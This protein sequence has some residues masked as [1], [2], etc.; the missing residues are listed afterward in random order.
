MLSFFVKSNNYFIRKII[1]FARFFSIKIFGIVELNLS[2]E[3]SISK[4]DLDKYFKNKDTEKTYS[5]FIKNLDSKSELVV[6]NILQRIEFNSKFVT[7]NNLT[8]KEL[9]D[10]L[11]LKNFKYFNYSSDTFFIDYFQKYY[12]GFTQYEIPVFKYHHG[13]KLFDKNILVY[14]RDK[15]VIDAGSFELDSAVIFSSNYNFKNIHSFEI[16]LINYEKSKSILK[17]YYNHIKNI[18]VINKGLWKHNKFIKISN[19]GQSTTKINK[20][21]I[22]N[23]KIE[24]ITID[25]YINKEKLNLGYIKMDIEG[26]EYEAILGAK[27]SIKK[28]LPVMSISIYHNLRDFFEI[29]PLIE[30]LAPNEYD[31]YVRKLAPGYSILETYLI[32]IPKKLN[33]KLLDYYPDEIYG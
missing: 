28:F 12:P 23:D 31:F 29:K 8:K 20:Q 33:S 32:C 3:Y 22:N 26:A 16:D 18:L 11:S 17:K 7:V 24:L 1:N 15:E 27:D 25:E 30:T 14:L 4:K 2:P 21:K 6:R 10:V 5:D 9:N 19:L 13:L